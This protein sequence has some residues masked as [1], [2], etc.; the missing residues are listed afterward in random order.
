MHYL[1]IV[2][3]EEF[4]ELG[5][6]GTGVKDYPL[7]AKGKN[8]IKDLTLVIWGEIHGYRMYPCDFGLCGDYG[9]IPDY[10]GAFADGDHFMIIAD[11]PANSFI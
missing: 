7:W 2:A 9:N 11:Q 3:F 5:T 10:P 6:F 8:I 1:D 4:I